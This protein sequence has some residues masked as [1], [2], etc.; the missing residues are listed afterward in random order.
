MRPE[1]DTPA[2]R[3]ARALTL[4]P[5]PPPLPPPPLPLPPRRYLASQVDLARF[6]WTTSPDAKNAV[7]EQLRDLFESLPRDDAFVLTSNGDGMFA[8]N[9][10]DAERV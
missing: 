10:F 1:A 8:Q 7:Y 3:H 2:W 5:C 9:G 4:G 6:R